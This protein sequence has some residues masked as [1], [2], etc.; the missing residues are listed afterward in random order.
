M[1]V[2]TIQG[3]SLPRACLPLDEQLEPQN[4]PLWRI[5]GLDPVFISSVLSVLES[6]PATRRASLGLLGFAA[7]GGHVSGCRAEGSR[8][9]QEREPV[10]KG[11]EGSQSSL[12][13]GRLTRVLHMCPREGHT[14]FV[15]LAPFHSP[16]LRG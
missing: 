10:R 15:S 3:Y 5:R 11:V 13:P 12:R 9:R 4:S 16:G 1:L 8:H 2:L 7:L 6:L 14:R